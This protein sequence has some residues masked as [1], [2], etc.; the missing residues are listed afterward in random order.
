[1]FSSN[2]PKLEEVNFRKVNEGEP[3]CIQCNQSDNNIDVTNN[4]VV[5]SKCYFF[6]I[7][8][9]ELHICDLIH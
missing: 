2:K 5:T 8:V 6:N 1:M 4:A 3:N 9:D 7:D